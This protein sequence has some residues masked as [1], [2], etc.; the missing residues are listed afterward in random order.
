MSLKLKSKGCP[1]RSLKLNLLS[2]PL[3][4][5]SKNSSAWNQTWNREI[6]NPPGPRLF[7]PEASYIQAC[8]PLNFLL[9]EAKT[10]AF[11]ICLDTYRHPRI[12]LFL[13]YISFCIFSSKGGSLGVQFVIFLVP[14]LHPHQNI[15]KAPAWAKLLFHSPT[16]IELA[17][18]GACS[19]CL[20]KFRTTWDNRHISYMSCQ[21][22][23]LNNSNVW[24]V[25]EP[26]LAN[27]QLRNW[28][29]SAAVNRQSRGIVDLGSKVPKMHLSV[30]H[31]I[32]YCIFT[33]QGFNVSRCFGSVAISW[34]S[35]TVAKGNMV[36]INSNKLPELASAEGAS[37]SAQF[38]LPRNYQHRG[39]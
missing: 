21:Y 8:L 16:N 9:H 35:G 6:W 4:V 30:Q 18:W 26:T 28:V 27:L 19:H 36:A 29:K 23:N 5:I 31:S 25:L 10:T 7:C 32:F 1:N 24:T 15:Q 2:I 14:S 17:T 3:S 13:A 38:F 37:C 12:F 20:D 39:D 33:H 34:P 22:L 11:S